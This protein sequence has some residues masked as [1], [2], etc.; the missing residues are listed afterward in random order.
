VKKL[1]LLLAVCALAA[2]GCSGGGSHAAI[3][4]TAPMGPPVN[5]QQLTTPSFT[6]DTS[7]LNG[8][9][10]V[11]RASV[12]RLSVDLV[13]RLQ[14]A[15]GLLS[16]AAAANTP[17]SGTYRHFLTPQQIGQHYGAS[18]SDY[19]AAEQYLR[20]KGLAVDGWPQRLLVHVTGTQAAVESALGTTFAWYRNANATFLAPAS[21]PNLPKNVPIIG[22]TNLVM[23]APTFTDHAL[24]NGGMSNG[25]TYGYSPQQIAA[26]FDYTG[27]YNAGFTGA[28]ITVGII[29]T[30][31]FSAADVPAYKS[32][33]HVSGSGTATLV[34]A[35]NDDN[36]GTS[37]SGFATPPPV[38]KP[39]FSPSSLPPAISPTATCN[40]EDGETQ[41]DTEQVAG[42][43]YDANIHY[44]LAYNAADGCGAVATT[45]PPG[46]GIPL[47]GLGEID[48]ELQTAIAENQSDV[49]SLSFGGPE[50]GQVGYAFNA[51][52][53]G[54]EPLEF[55][56]LA[57][58]GIAIFVSS[59]DS[60]AEEC[61][62]FTGLP[63]PDSLCVSYPATD[64]SVVSVGGTNTPLNAAGNLVGPLTGWGNQTSMGYGG[65]GGG[66]SAYFPL[67][68]FQQGAAGVTGSMRNVPDVA[69]NGDNHTGVATV[70]DAD[71]LLGGRKIA[72]YGGTSVA[73]PETAAMWA[74]VLQACKQTSSCATASG[75]APYRLGNP[76]VYFYKIYAN[77]AQYASVF[78]DV[79]Y[80]NNAMSSTCSDP[81]SPCP[82]NDPGYSAGVGYDLITGIGAP[83][84]RALITAVVGR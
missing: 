22:A 51:S 40:P 58:E 47:Q 61:M 69:L 68:A 67:P 48:A 72:D 60:G 21:A 12:G 11:S 81:A 78:T 26:V 39:C 4:A 25:M 63:N 18:Q 6:Y 36:A 33:F 79:L 27:A 8:A 19:T 7:Q 30:G 77:A 41:I 52:G 2:A 66:V 50:T 55:A 3:P 75:A 37:S 29:G 10:M 80:G 59:G 13:P 76:N 53:H 35:T 31:G 73:A 23:R 17:T 62:P 32:L 84:A 42:L 74:L 38:T 28:G 20:G 56:A 82:S 64:P 16:Y 15:S 54:L 83:H 65:S 43:A 49:L 71:P 46:T 34:A 44:Y 1:S 9:T 45:C 24:A 70:L 57:S 5:P 14:N